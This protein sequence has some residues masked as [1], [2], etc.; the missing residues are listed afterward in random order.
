MIVFSGNLQ[1]LQDKHRAIVVW[2]P[3]KMAWLGSWFQ[4]CPNLFV[5]GTKLH[6]YGGLS[7]CEQTTWNC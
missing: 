3:L 2:C 7:P 5:I 6:L 4:Q 1:C